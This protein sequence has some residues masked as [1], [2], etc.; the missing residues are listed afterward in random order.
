V[1]CLDQA[2]GVT[3]KAMPQAAALLAASF[4]SSASYKFAICF[5]HLGCN[6][7]FLC[8]LT[9]EVTASYSR[10]LFNFASVR[11]RQPFLM[12]KDLYGNSIFICV[13]HT[14][15]DIKARA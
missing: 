6:L 13:S 15:P 1:C 5:L 11:S 3:G 14:F 10:Q 4:V 2:A 12:F 8:T 9:L 7:F